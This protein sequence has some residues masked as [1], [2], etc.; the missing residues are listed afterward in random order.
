MLILEKEKTENIMGSKVISFIEF[1]QS[2]YQNKL[3][4]YVLYVGVVGDINSRSF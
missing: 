3:H 4:M 1:L 2:K